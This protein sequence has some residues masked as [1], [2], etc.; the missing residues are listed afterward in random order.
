MIDFPYILIAVGGLF[1][2]MNW[3]AFISSRR[4]GRFDSP[5]P[6]IG[7]LLLGCGMA[8]YLPTRPFA[9]LAVVADYGTLV[10]IV[11]SPRIAY[12]F[13][14]TSRINLLHSFMTNVAGRIIRIDLFRRHVAVIS[15]RFDPSIPAN[16][17]GAR[18]C[19]FGMVGRWDST[20]TGFSINGYR[21][22]RQ[23][24][25]TKEDSTYSTI[26]L[27]YPTSEEFNGDGLN[28]LILHR[29]S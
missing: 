6:L 27:N 1:S 2:F 22:D 3:R 25:I 7:A 10:L 11:A 15:A 29:Q 20:P 21:S 26:E 14:S 19:S 17:D 13:W 8:L 16:H 5:I 24:I 28:G 4:N 18:I 9:L 12:D 23:L